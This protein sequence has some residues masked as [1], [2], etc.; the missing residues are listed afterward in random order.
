MQ[1]ALVTG[2]A[3]GIG[4]AIAL[5]L[6]HRGIT[7]LAVSARTEQKLS[8]AKEVLEASGAKALV[9]HA[10]VRDFDAM[11]SVIGETDKLLGRI[12]VLVNNAGVA[13]RTPFLHMSPA[14]WDEIVDVNLK[15]VFACTALVLPRM[16]ANGKGVI[17]NIASGAGKTG[18]PELAVYCASKFGVVG[19]TESLAKELKGS[20][21][22]V[23]AVCPGSTDTRMYRSLYLEREP[24]VKPEDVAR[25]VCRL[26]AGEP[27]VP[28]GRCVEVY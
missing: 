1:T 6:A 18:F 11:A 27:V 25:V 9:F 23:Y 24:A 22:R 21:V 12:D 7:R 2:G 17:V 5:A 14:A 4:L 10:D 26:V 13:L 8:E 3:R 15:G 28:P 20:G 19:F 16:L